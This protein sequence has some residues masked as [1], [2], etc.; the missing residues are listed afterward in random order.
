MI[1]FLTRV[2][3]RASRAVATSAPSPHADDAIARGP[4]R[5]RERRATLD[6]ARERGRARIRRSRRDRAAARREAAATR[7]A[8]DRARRTDAPTGRGDGRRRRGDARRRRARRESAS[9]RE[10][11]RVEVRGRATAAMRR[12]GDD[13]ARAMRARATR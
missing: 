8:R 13:G 7:R 1:C 12:R 9:A 2:L 6:G 10:R 11:S 5:A 3:D 4:S